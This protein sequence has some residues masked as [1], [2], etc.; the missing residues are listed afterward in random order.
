MDRDENTAF[1]RSYRSEV[2]E[3]FELGRVVDEEW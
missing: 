1:R 2:P 3:S